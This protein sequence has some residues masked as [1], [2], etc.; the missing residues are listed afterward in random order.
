MSFYI[1]LPSNVKSYSQTNTQ[2]NYT[3]EFDDPLKIEGNY[4]V[5][6]V[7]FTFREFIEI[8]LGRM[9]INYESENNKWREFMLYAYENEPIDHFFDRINFEIVEYYTNLAYYKTKEKLTDPY[10]SNHRYNLKRLKETDNE[11]DIE[12]YHK[13]NDEIKKKCPIFTKIPSTNRVV[14][15][16]P[17]NT[18]IKFD[19][20]IKKVFKLDNRIEYSTGFEF[21]MLS[22]LLNFYDVLYV[23]CD[24]ISYQRI[25]DQYGKLIRTITKTSEFNKSIEKIYT[26]PHYLPVCKNFINSINIIVAATTGIPV[27]FA[28]ETSKVVVKLHFRPCQ[29]N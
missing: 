16:I 3:T 4:E 28:S 12:S 29:D 15:Q 7:E 10:N 14:V 21:Y 13:I 2:S 19:G 9:M 11:I 1:T 24:I 8:E 27:H 23:Y 6:L 25:G 17:I 26:N 5:A 18:K 22:E 20:Y